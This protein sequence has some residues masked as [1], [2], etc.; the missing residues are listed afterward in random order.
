MRLGLVSDTHGELENLREAARR[1]VREWRVEAIAHL[2]DECEDVVVLEEFPGPEII[3]VP[4]VFCEHYRDPAIPNRLVRELAGHRVLFTHTPTS[5]AN[6]LPGD[7]KPEEL[8][9]CREVDVVAFGHTHVPL[10]EE[11]DGVLWVNPGHLKG[12]DKRGHAPSF[13]VVDLAADRVEVRLVDLAGGV[14]TTHFVW[15]RK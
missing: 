6:D 7:P 15:E 3:R 11:R 10:V 8:V 9:A 2:G 5:H 13:A 4:G 1:L 14:V 12:Q